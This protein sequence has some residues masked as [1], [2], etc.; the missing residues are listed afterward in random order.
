VSTEAPPAANDTAT[1]E[2]GSKWTCWQGALA[3]FATLLAIDHAT[4]FWAKAYLMPTEEHPGRVI[5]LIPGC[6]DFTYAENTGAAF[7]ML[8]EHTEILAGF[9]ILATAGFLWFF[10]TLPS[11]EKWGRLAVGAILSGAVGNL[12]DRVF[13]GYVVDFIHA[14]WG[15]YHWP[16]F[17]IA[18]CAITVGAAVLV[19]QGI[20][21][22]L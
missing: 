16:V 10:T 11:R 3:I 17:N 19:L 21:G 12:I 20:R 4:K 22:K 1:D 9:S 2:P 18:D 8:S 15:Q 14:W 6:L 5:V 13:R 7:S